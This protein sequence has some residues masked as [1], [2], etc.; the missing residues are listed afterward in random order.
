MLDISYKCMCV[1]YDIMK[2]ND[3]SNRLIE[4]ADGSVKV[5]SKQIEKMNET[6]TELSRM[7]TEQ[8]NYIKQIKKLKSDI[9]RVQKKV[10]GKEA[11]IDKS[12]NEQK[13]KASEAGDGDIECPD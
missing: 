8:Q 4:G 13:K 7:K 9:K 1:L 3:M 11:K 12:I 6:E 2:S 10:D 5:S